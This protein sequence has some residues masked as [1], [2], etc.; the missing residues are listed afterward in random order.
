MY[1]FCYEPD[2]AISI[3]AIWVLFTNNKTFLNNP[4]VR[5]QLT[6]YD[7][8]AQPK[9]FWTDDYSSVLQRF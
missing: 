1:S 9:V 2:R 5:E 3:N 4:S 8:N 6:E 7:I